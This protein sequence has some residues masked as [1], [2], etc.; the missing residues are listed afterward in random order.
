MGIWAGIKHALNSTL[1]TNNF[2]PLDKIFYQGK[3]TIASENP[4]YLISNGGNFNYNSTSN[5]DNFSTGVIGKTFV[6]KSSGSFKVSFN[7]TY[8]S[9]QGSGGIGVYI[10]DVRKTSRTS[11]EV[12]DALLFTEPVSY[13][14]GDVITIKVARIYD[15]DANSSKSFTISNI[16]FCADIVDVSMFDI[17]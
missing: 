4:L 17:M 11:R 16:Q 7:L 5:D 14:E 8:S 15:N 1:G 12:S 2:K 9:S 13:S 10:N 6:A 3:S